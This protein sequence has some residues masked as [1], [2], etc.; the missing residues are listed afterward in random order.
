MVSL[1]VVSSQKDRRRWSLLGKKRAL[2]KINKNKLVWVRPSK[3]LEKTGGFTHF[4]M[5]SQASPKTAF[6][7]SLKLGKKYSFCDFPG[8]AALVSFYLLLITSSACTIPFSS[9]EDKAIKAMARE[10]MRKKKRW[11][12]SILCLIRSDKLSVVS[13]IKETVTQHVS[14]TGSVS[15]SS[16]SIQKEQAVPWL[17]DGC[18]EAVSELR[19]RLMPWYSLRLRRPQTSG[20]QDIA[21]VGPAHVHRFPS[22]D[23]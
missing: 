8:I 13:A 18:T 19:G 23:H 12:T 20:T 4:Q 15:F 17:R 16:H 22:H 3:S 11:I 9:T 5:S 7:W 2:P 1:A 14:C 6:S 21:G 10:G